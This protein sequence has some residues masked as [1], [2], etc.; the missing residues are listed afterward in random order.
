MILKTEWASKKEQALN[1]IKQLK[2][3]QVQ[4]QDQDP[5]PKE[6]IKLRM[7]GVRNDIRPEEVRA[8]L[9]H[10]APISGVK[11][12]KIENG[13]ILVICNGKEVHD[14]I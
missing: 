2:Q 10:A 4:D 14:L 1:L 5:V 11:Y 3:I 13:T 9:G 7:N 12:V 6:E 8:A